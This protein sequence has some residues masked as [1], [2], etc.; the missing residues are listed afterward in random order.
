MTDRITLFSLNLGDAARLAPPNRNLSE[1][2]PADKAVSLFG[3][4]PQTN[5]G[6]ANVDQV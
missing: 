3:Y 1:D 5:T 2:M 4:K 6:L